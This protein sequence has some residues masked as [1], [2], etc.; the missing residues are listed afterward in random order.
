MCACWL[1]MEGAVDFIVHPDASAC[2]CSRWKVAGRRRSSKLR[3]SGNLLPNSVR[4]QM[5]NGGQNK[6]TVAVSSFKEVYAKY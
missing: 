5:T 3:M 4:R 1:L 2:V 6:Q